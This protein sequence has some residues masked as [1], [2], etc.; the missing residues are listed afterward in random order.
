MTG[1]LLDW[2]LRGRS[3][4]L[5]LLIMGSAVALQQLPQLRIDR[6]DERL[7]SSNDAGWAAVRE[8]QARFGAEQSILIYLRA[9]DLWT[10]PRLRALEDF[11]LALQEIPDISTVESVLTATNIRDKGSFVDAG[12]L[13]DVVPDSV[14]RIAELKAD[15]LY[16]PLIRRGFVSADGNATA[17]LVGYRADPGNPD[18]DLSIYAAIEQ[19][20]A[21]VEKSFDK[22]FQL[23]WPRLSAEIDAGLK[24]DLARLVPVSLLLLVGTMTVF[25]RSVRVVP[26]P[27]VTCGITILWTLGFMAA[28]GIPITLLTAILPALIIVVGAVEDVHLVAS[29]LEGIDS[30]DP[31]PRRAAV[32]YMAR[33]VGPAI[34][35][36]SFTTVLGFASNMTS[37]IP[38]IREFAL[39]ASFA[40]FANL[41]VTVCAVPVLLQVWGP[42]RN[43]LRDA[44]GKLRGPIGAVVRLVERATERHA[45]WLV[46]G[47]LIVLAVF[48]VRIG[49]VKV[50]NDPMAYFPADHPFVLDAQRVQQD[51][52]GVQ[53]FGVMLHS[54]APGWFRTVEGLAAI[55]RVERYLDEQGIYDRTTSLADLMALMH[56]EMHAGDVAFDRIPTNQQDYDLYLS[57]MP[58]A[59]LVR[60]VTEDFSHALIGV[61]HSVADSV[62][63]NAAVDDLNDALPAVLGHEAHFALAGE[64]L[65]VNRA[66]ESLIDG[67]ALSLLILL[68]VIFVTF[69]ILYTSWMA[70]LLALVPNILPIVINFGLMGWLGVPLNPGTAMVAAIAIGLAVD[71]TIHLMTRFGVESRQKVDER[72]AVVATLRGEA[73][74]VLGS[75]V[76]LSLG[77]AVFGLSSFRVVVE[78]GLLAA[79]TMCYAALADLLLMPILLRHLRLATVWDIVALD[80]DPAVLSRCPLFRGMSTYQVK[81]LILLSE[82]VEFAP[83]ELLIA[84]GDVSTG[85]YVL[86]RGE[87]SISIDEGGRPLV[88]DR[89]RAGDIFGEI[90]FAGTG[91]P[92]TA[93]IAAL[94]AIVAVRLD[95]GRMGRGLRFYPSLAMQ[96]YKNISQ[97]LGERLVQSHGRLLKVTAQSAHR[98]V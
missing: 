32:K 6:S 34:V 43:D 38:L 29:Y 94:S 56:K 93:T 37:E 24:H 42:T 1:R 3:I 67:E 97:L 16:S 40:M 71:D 65:M 5:A 48:G 14:E 46:A 20:I 75:A 11:T 96:L 77:F 92:R 70:G 41:V 18:H 39:A 4:G 52:A 9:D 80:V 74:P 81:K 89:G 53:S 84:Q 95:A 98:R 22:A 54:H 7:V 26:I 78:F 79:G 10:R 49:A 88:I 85:M 73:V 68:G 8:M 36:T 51:L 86:L 35:V 76:A 63:L 21:K 82:L 66:A 91:V 45:K 58:R 61:R 50:N 2:G 59:E 55:A 62:R 13:V 12:P 30:G 17:V 47:F 83:G 33:H 15:A 87:V 44:G 69:A 28:C 64:N 57:G 19:R 25:L 72:A 60:L 23:G 31:R 90:A 27:L